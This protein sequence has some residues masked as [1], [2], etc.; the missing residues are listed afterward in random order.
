MRKDKKI[1]LKR[2]AQVIF[3]SLIAIGIIGLFV[4]V[5]Q[6]KDVPLLDTHGTIANQ[7]RDLIYLTFGLGLLVVIPV[8]ILLFSVAWR[9][10]AGNKKAKYQPDMDGNKGL[11]ALWWGI[12]CLI[13]IALAIIIHCLRMKSKLCTDFYISGNQ[14]NAIIVKM[15][16]I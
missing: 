6:G 5:T 3:S 15:Q 1:V 13:I 11:E 10:R 8:L 2:V 4:F 12:P 7:Q 16:F 14:I 9:Y